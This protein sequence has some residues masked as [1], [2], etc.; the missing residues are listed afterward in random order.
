MFSITSVWPS[1]RPIASATMRATT[2]L[3]PPAG[4]GTTTVMERLG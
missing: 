4:N 2:S 1:E 3:G